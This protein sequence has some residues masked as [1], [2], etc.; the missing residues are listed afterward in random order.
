MLWHACVYVS[1]IKHMGLMEASLGIFMCCY[2]NVPLNT[3]IS[4]L[5]LSLLRTLAVQGLFSK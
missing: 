2:A 4:L 1:N 3:P 5:R